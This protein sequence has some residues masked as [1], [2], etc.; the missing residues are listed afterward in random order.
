MRPLA[1][2]IVEKC[3][4]TVAAAFGRSRHA[5]PR[6]Y[7]SQI[8]RSQGRRTPDFKGMKEHHDLFKMSEP[9]C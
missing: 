2:A 7:I 9:E 3:G 5:H 4:T 8:D 6:S 1:G